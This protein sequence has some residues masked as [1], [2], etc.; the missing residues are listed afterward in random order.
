MTNTYYS[1]LSVGEKIS[2]DKRYHIGEVTYDEERFKGHIYYVLNGNPEYKEVQLT[3]WELIRNKSFD[4]KLQREVEKVNRLIEKERDRASKRIIAGR[5]AKEYNK[6]MNKTTN[7]LVKDL[8][9]KYQFK[10]PGN[11]EEEN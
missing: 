5:P 9:A 6:R 2:M 10:K 3:M 8:N 4:D 1:Q 7:E 11:N